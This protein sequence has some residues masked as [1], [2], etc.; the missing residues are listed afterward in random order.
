MD[1]ENPLIQI[2][3]HIPSVTGRVIKISELKL[4]SVLDSFFPLPPNPT[5]HEIK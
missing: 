3:A 5:I 2:T 1:I 4:L